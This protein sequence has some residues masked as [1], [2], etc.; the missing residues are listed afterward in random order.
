MNKVKDLC[1]ASCI[2][3]PDSNAGALAALVLVD[4]SGSLQTCTGSCLVPDCGSGCCSYDY[5][6]RNRSG[7]SQKQPQY[8]C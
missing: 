6:I 4:V 2:V 8:H 1:T 5:L 3:L 7:T